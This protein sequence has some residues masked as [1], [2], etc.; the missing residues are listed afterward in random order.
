MEKYYTQILEKAQFKEINDYNFFS[1]CKYF[2]I[3][4]ILEVD[5]KETW[6]VKKYG[7]LILGILE[8]PKSGSIH[9][10]ILLLI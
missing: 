6:E 2:M 4:Y 9:H 3:T 10:N 7:I 5:N 1:G 8:K